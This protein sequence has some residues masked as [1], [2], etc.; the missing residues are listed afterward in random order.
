MQTRS[1]P[2]RARAGTAVALALTLLVLP[3]ASRPAQA[4]PTPR[5]G[6]PEQDRLAAAERQALADLAESSEQVRSAA[7][8]LSQV[9]AQLPGAQSAVAKAR[10]G[11]AGAR[12]KV[13]AATAELEE[14]ERAQAAAAKQVE[15]ADRRVEQGRQDVGLM[16]RRT[17]QRGRLGDLREVVDAGEP[18]DVLERATMLRSVFEHQDAALDRLTSARLALAGRQASLA[19]ERRA[20]AKARA[21]A[22]ER[23]ERARALAEQAE[24]A[25]ARVTSLLAARADALQSAEGAQ[26]AD[27]ADYA[28][29]QA[30]SRALAERIREA[31]RRAAA[32]QARRKA[33]AE[34]AARAA[35]T[36]AAAEAAARAA[37]S[38][39][40]RQ[41]RERQ[42]ADAAQRASRQSRPSRRQAAPDLPSTAS[43]VGWLW[44]C[45]GCPQTSSFGWRPHPIFGDRRLHAGI[46][47]GAPIGHP[48]RAAES[49]T[50]LIAGSAAGYGTLVVVGHGGALST[51][52][53]HMSAISVSPGQSVGRGEKV[54]EV[55]NEG[56]STGPH[57]HFEVRRNGEPVDPSAFVGGS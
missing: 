52:Y 57:L 10:G 27:Q 2:A 31:A 14:A 53:A 15:A 6:T 16:A 19:A 49:G 25:A 11:L 18:Q 55:G 26:A 21:R 45:G 56:N 46:D 47:M 42:A 44:P 40:Q 28:Q 4:G 9:A 54:G 34:A 50:V 35:A 33:E 1:S 39:A 36:K 23:E 41:E 12:A 7:V 22:Q 32:E 43:R 3:G 5:A 29:A 24:D 30:A 20:V 8:A 38:A 37:A 17:Y 48:V 13:A 51:A